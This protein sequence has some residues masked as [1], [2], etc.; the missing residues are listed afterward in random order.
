ML[1][2]NVVAYLN[3][4]TMINGKNHC[5]IPPYFTILFIF[6]CLQ[7][8]MDLIEQR[9]PKILQRGPYFVRLKCMGGGGGA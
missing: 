5:Y 2:N 1:D 9:C 7:S 6:N 3:S 4:D 8:R